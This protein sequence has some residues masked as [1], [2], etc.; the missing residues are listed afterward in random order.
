MLLPFSKKIDDICFHP[1]KYESSYKFYLVDVIL[2]M[3]DAMEIQCDIQVKATR[4]LGKF[5]VVLEDI[6]EDLK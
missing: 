6:L 2:G 1:D 5:K 4:D 3:L